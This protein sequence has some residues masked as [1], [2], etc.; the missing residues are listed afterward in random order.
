MPQ[1]RWIDG[2]QY[3]RIA[4]YRTKLEAE[5]YYRQLKE[6]DKLS[7]PTDY[8]DYVVLQDSNSWYGVYGLNK[9]HN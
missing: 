4:S 1:Y 2:K 6:T 8:I 5:R 7:F 9:F 3:T